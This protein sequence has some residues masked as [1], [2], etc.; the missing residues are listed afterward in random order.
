ML[1]TILALSVEAFT[2]SLGASNIKIPKGNLGRARVG[3][4]QPR[5]DVRKWMGRKPFQYA[6]LAMSQPLEKAFTVFCGQSSEAESTRNARD[7]H[8][9]MKS[10]QLIPDSSELDADPVAL[11][12]SPYIWSFIHDV[13][14]PASRHPPGSAAI[15]CLKNYFAVT[16]MRLHAGI[17]VESLVTDICNTTSVAEFE[18][19]LDGFRLYVTRDIAGDSIPPLPPSSPA[20]V[21]VNKPADRPDSNGSVPTSS[22]AITKPVSSSGGIQ[23]LLDK[24][25]DEGLVILESPK[26]GYFRRSRT[27]KGKR[28]PPSCKEK[29]TVRE[30]QVLCYIEQLGGEIPIE[31]DIAGEVIKI[32]RK[33]GDPIGYGDPLIVILPSFPGI[34]LLQ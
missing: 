25:A 33:D 11:D 16:W 18:L 13:K 5:S 8:E 19:K 23:T 7:G 12:K 9:D 30:G 27:I 10:P 21:T 15:N 28:A 3:D 29:Q 2:D 14:L 22:L 26:V 17:L 6:G 4:L 31:S 32:L 1:H 20:P 24:A 34:K